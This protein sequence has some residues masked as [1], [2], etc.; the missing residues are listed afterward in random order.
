[1]D[2]VAIEYEDE[3]DDDLMFSIE[4]EDDGRWLCEVEAIPGAIAYGAHP[5]EA[6]AKAFKIAWDAIAEAEKQASEAN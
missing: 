3:S 4:E 1:M 2:D 5:Y 6:I